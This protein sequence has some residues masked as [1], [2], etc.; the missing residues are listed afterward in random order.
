MALILSPPLLVLLYLMCFLPFTRPFTVIMSDS[1]VPSALIDGPQ[2]G[3]SMNNNSGARTDARE[4]GAVYDIMRATGNG[5]ATDIPDV[6]RGRW[7]GIECMPD[8]DNV[9]HVVSLSFGALSDDTA[10]PT[11]DPT[12]SFISPSITKLPHLRTLFFYRCFTH[13]P[14]PIPSFLGNLGPTLRTLVLRENGHVGPIP[15]ELGNLTRLKVLDLH[16]NNLN[17]SIPVSLGRITGLKS[18]DLSGNR[19]TGPIPSLSFP[20]L[21]IIDLSQNLLLGSIPS[22]IGTC[23]SLVKIDFSRN[24]L[25]GRIPDSINGLTELMLLD[26]SFNRLSGP[27]PLSLRSLISLQALI[28]KGNQMGSAAI[29]DDAFDGMKGLMILILSNMNIH[30]PIPASL[31]QLSNLRVLHLDGNH[32]NGSIPTGFGELRNLSELR[33]NDNGLVGL[34][35]FGKEMVWK[36]RRK[37]RL[38]NNSGLCYRANSG[39]EDNF[40][41]GIGLC[42]SARPGSARTVQHLSTIERDMPNTVNGSSGSVHKSSVSMGTLLQILFMSSI[43]I[44]L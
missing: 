18:L 21:S 6:C 34:I 3:F 17:G 4:Q 10:F 33:L 22:S 44:L 23:H 28:L 12:R 26:L 15:N 43:V 13:N 1:G 41:S 25:S 7:H 38:Y 36:M 24:R 5:W 19:L 35:P 37:L 16:D 32:L 27:L 42:E 31:G 9:Y 39:L 11:C 8:K 20:V 14:Q 40:N 29:P 30:G 2:T